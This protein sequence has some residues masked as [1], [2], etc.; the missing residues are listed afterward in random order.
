[1]GDVQ[2]PQARVG[3]AHTG[4]TN[5][6]PGGTIDTGDDHA[7]YSD[8]SKGGDESESS[9]ALTES[10]DRQLDSTAS[11]GE[12]EVGKVGGGDGAENVDPS[13]GEAG[14]PIS[15]SEVSSGGGAPPDPHGVG[16]SSSQRGETLEPPSTE[17][18]GP[19][20]RPVGQVEGDL[21]EPNDSGS[22]TSDIT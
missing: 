5:P 12:A 19:T 10:I 1:M 7:P 21:M 15:A 11:K 6:Y 14:D 4:G 22:G 13:T 2:E 20:K 16:T 17:H 8:R 3:G 18:E 9:Q